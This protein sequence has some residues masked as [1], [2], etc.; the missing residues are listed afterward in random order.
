VAP[1]AQVVLIT[2]GYS[3][4]VGLAGMGVLYLVR[5]RSLGTSL[6]V[7]SITVILTMV[8]GTL[9]AARAMSFTAHDLQ[10]IGIASVVAGAVATATSLLVGRHLVAGSRALRE[11]TRRLGA[12]ERYPGVDADPARS[13]LTAELSALSA[14]LAATSERLAAS[15]ERERA[16]EAS[17]RELVAWVSHDLRTPLAGL[18]A[19]AEALEDGVAD[20]P[21]RYHKQMRIETDRLAAMVEDLFELSRLHAG[22]LPLVLEQISLADLVS[23]TLAGADALARTRGVLL[24]GRATPPVTVR[25]DGTQLSRVLANLVVNAIRHTRPGGAV[26]I[27]ARSEEGTAVLAVCDGC[28]GIPSGDLERIF[29]IGWR[30]TH[31]RT[32]GPDGGAGLGLAIV[33]GVVEAHAGQ[34]NV[35]NTGPGCRF[36]VRLPVIGA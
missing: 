25:A 33:K 4:A 26:Q 13:A 11:A 31:A 6:A 22:A 21:G 5:R 29:D 30:G 17:R 2:A 35:I 8:A 16:I 34:V 24:T 36:E 7:I 23:D 20:D 14:E 10:I 32:P 18:R 27:E 3:G 9:G 19:M 1:D 12:E 15:R 28:G